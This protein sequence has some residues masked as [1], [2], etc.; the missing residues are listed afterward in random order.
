V[1]GY[2]RLGGKEYREDIVDQ[3][4]A[5]GTAASL[6][7]NAVARYSDRPAL[8]DGNIRWSYREFGDAVGRFIALFR[9]VGLKRGD[10]L[11]VLAGNRAESWAAISAAMVMG[12]RY[13]P[14]HPMAAE[15]D[16]VFIISDAEID[17]L[18]VEAG[19]FAP[20]GLAIKSRVPSLKHVLSFGPVEGARDLLPELPK[21]APAP[22]VDESDVNA[23]AWL[24]YTGGTTGRS[25]GVMLPHR[26]VTTMAT[27]LYADWDWP[28]EIR[29]LAATP[30]SHAAGVTLYPVM[31]RGG[32]TRLVQGFEAEAYCRVVAEEKITAAFLVPTLIYAL[33]D[34]PDLRAR[35]DMS[36]LDMIVYGAAPMSPDRLREGMDIFGPVFVQLYGQTEAPQ[37]ITTMRKI[38]HDDSKPGRL[39]SC[40]RPNPLVDVKLFDSEMREVAI[41]EPGEIC[42]RGT[43]VMD[44]YWKRSEATEE[45]FRGGWLHTGDVAIKDEEGYL[46]IVDRTKDM[47]ISGGF[48]IYPREVED[49]LMSHQAV[50][51]AAV[52]GVP[53]DKWGEAVKAFVV[54]KSGANNGAAELQAHVKEKR[55]APWSPKTIEFV[56]EIPVTGLGKIDRKALRAPYWEG[57]QRGV[58]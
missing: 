21:V 8:A 44:G 46:Y 18:I 3:L 45:A 32:F 2:E 40:G 19:K 49:A 6:I 12:L 29:F 22:I 13:T 52:I 36:S 34:A 24:A 9:S 14:L 27:L 23:I 33:I 38:D 17:A 58:A 55:G 5:G 15:D 35:Y 1:R 20:R 42:V 41:G 56:A 57:R 54:L 31:M 51:S 37:C 30:I 11:S 50:A 53:D 26:V 10:A 48:N 47:I 39:G 25:K 4:H 28:P 7:V 43:L 16:H